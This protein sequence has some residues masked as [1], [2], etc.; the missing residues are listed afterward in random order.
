ML[1]EFDVSAMIDVSDGL[2]ADLS[3]I[4]DESNVGFSI[5]LENIPLFPGVKDFCALIDIDAYIFAARSGEE[6]ELLFTA[7]PKIGGKIVREFT[8]KL[9]I[10][11]KVIGKITQKKRIITLRER[12]MLSKQLEGWQHPI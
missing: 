11:V 2:F 7:P 10:P 1:G 8:K 6:F 5:K 9:D 4:A 12:K 3:H